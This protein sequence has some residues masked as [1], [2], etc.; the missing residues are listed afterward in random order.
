MRISDAS[1]W[2]SLIPYWIVAVPV[3]SP[4]GRLMDSMTGGSLFATTKGALVP[5]D[6][7]FVSDGV[8]RTSTFDTSVQA[9]SASESHTKP[10]SVPPGELARLDIPSP[11]APSVQA[12]KV[13]VAPARHSTVTFAG[14]DSASVSV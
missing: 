9:V 10:W 7:C 5:D 13:P 3:T 11:P 4:D 8:I 14:F 12:W 1:E 2:V 6:P